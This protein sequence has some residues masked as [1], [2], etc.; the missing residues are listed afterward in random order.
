MARYLIV[1]AD[2]YNLTLGV[3]RGILQAHRHGIV[4][5]TTVLVNLPGLERCRDLARETPDL[6]LGL[7]L[8]LTHGIPVRPPAR[9]PSL[10]ESTGRFPR[11]P[12]RFGEP[13][14]SAEIR[15]EFT[16]QVDHF[17][18]TFGRPPTHLDTHH[19]IHRQ[20]LVLEIL[21]ELAHGLSVPVR[22]PSPDGVGVLRAKGIPSVDRTVGDVDEAALR[23]PRDLAA[24]LTALPDG[25]TELMCHPGY[26]DAELAMSSYQREREQELRA[27]CDPTLREAIGRAGIRR[28]GY[29][30]LAEALETRS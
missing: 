26:C 29:R 13:R 20:P 4:T 17:V 12:A 9:L 6:G 3:S 25:F 10:V 28:I 27:L 23:D 1:N 18:A 2:D 21:T 8:N 16:A 24:L 14:L 22:P 5:S 7:H 19:H 11:R 15:G 30:D